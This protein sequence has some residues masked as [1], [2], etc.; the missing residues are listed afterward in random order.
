M[1][2]FYF[3]LVSLG[4]SEWKPAN[5]VVMA[6]DV[7]QAKIKLIEE[8]MSDRFQYLS[9]DVEEEE[10]EALH[11]ELKTCKASH[12]ESGVVLI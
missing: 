3:N 4:E 8:V 6:E 11:E 10:L 5:I 2:M 1:N 9:E 7:D 12:I